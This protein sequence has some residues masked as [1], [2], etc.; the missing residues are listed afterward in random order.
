MVKSIFFSN[1]LT[2]EIPWPSMAPGHQPRDDAL[3]A[4]VEMRQEDRRGEAVQGQA[5]DAGGGAPQVRNASRLKPTEKMLGE[6]EIH[7]VM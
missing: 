7:I 6:E 3:G 1:E 2:H 4:F 5:G